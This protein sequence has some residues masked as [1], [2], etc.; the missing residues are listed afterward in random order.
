MCILDGIQKN[1]KIARQNRP[2]IP[3]QSKRYTGGDYRFL[4][5]FNY[6]GCTKVVPFFLS[7]PGPLLNQK[8][9]KKDAYS[10]VHFFENLK[11]RE[12]LLITLFSFL[13]D[14]KG[15]RGNSKKK[16]TTFVHPRY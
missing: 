1:E 15:V 5:F 2:K 14:S 6:R 7:F 4:D 12:R 9:K 10:V 16:G 13:T 11:N 3:A 8:T